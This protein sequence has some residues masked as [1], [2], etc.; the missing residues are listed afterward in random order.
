MLSDSSLGLLSLIRNS[1]WTPKQNNEAFY[2]DE[3]LFT[4]IKPAG[5]DQ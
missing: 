2:G 3:R 4:S 1:V 5:L